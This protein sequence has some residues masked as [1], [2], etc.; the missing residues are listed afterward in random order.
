GEEFRVQLLRLG[1]KYVHIAKEMVYESRLA[2]PLQDGLCHVVF[3]V[4]D[5]GRARD[6]AV[7]AGA[8][9]VAPV[10]RVSAGFG[11]RQ[12]AFLRSPGGILFE[13]V[14]ILENAVPELP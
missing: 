2:H 4:D 3:E 12:V 6:K 8:T 11:T 5:L 14:R 7:A 1:D 13:L 10:S 9:E